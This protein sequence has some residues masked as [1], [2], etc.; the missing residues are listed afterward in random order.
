[1]GMRDSFWA[2]LGVKAADSRGEAL[3]QVR[4]AMLKVI[5]EQNGDERLRLDAK[6]SFATNLEALWYLRPELMQMIAATEGEGTAKVCIAAITDLFRGYQ[7]GG[8]PSRFSAL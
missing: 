8:V 7:P 6:I 5:D 1:M 3:E 2:L 4:R